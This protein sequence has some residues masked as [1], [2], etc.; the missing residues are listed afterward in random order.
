MSSPP[1]R[2]MVQ[3]L[4]PHRGRVHTA[5]P[6]RKKGGAQAVA[7]D[8]QGQPRSDA[9]RARVVPALTT[10]C[11]GRARRGGGGTF[12]DAGLRVHLVGRSW[13]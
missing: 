4:K 2:H 10:V 7:S 12:S 11:H 5:G 6:L 8:L 1:A 3:A 13:K 9:A